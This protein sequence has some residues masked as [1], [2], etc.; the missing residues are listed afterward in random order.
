MTNR[1]KKEE[2]RVKN[3]IAISFA[4]AATL[5]MDSSHL[6]LHSSLISITQPFWQWPP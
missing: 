1:Q 3:P 2:G 6:P 4:F 5:P